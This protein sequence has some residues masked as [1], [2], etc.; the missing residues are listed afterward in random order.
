MHPLIPVQHPGAVVEDM[1]QGTCCPVVGLVS[2]ST[3]FVGGIH[4]LAPPGQVVKVA[5]ELVDALIGKDIT[6]LGTA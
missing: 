2:C 5:K 6:P 1:P 4:H 3:Q